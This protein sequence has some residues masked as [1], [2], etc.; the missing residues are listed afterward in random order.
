MTILF[1]A[2]IFYAGTIGLESAVLGYTLEPVD[3]YFTAIQRIFRADLVPDRPSPV[4][5]L[6]VQL[7]SLQSTAADGGAAREVRLRVCDV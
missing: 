6:Y 4:S 7:R 1:A 3:Q 5:H 2:F